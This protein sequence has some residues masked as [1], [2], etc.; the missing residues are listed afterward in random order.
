M[1]VKN[2]RQSMTYLQSQWH[3][4]TM[5]M[6]IKWNTLIWPPLELVLVRGVASSELDY[7]KTYTLN[8]PYYYTCRAVCI[9]PSGFWVPSYLYAITNTHTELIDNANRPRP[10]HTSISLMR[11]LWSCEKLCW[12]TPSSDRLVLA[13]PLATPSTTPPFPFTDTSLALAPIFSSTLG[14]VKVSG[15]RLVADEEEKRSLSGGWHN[16][17]D[18]LTPWY[19]LY[20]Q[21]TMKLIQCSLLQQSNQILAINIPTRWR[22]KE[23][24]WRFKLPHTV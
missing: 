17:P 9:M 7:Y 24:D 1:K 11:P 13:T 15:V 23:I 5:T 20:T 16:V 18:L 12:S 21:G 6:G 19:A 8:W 14:E 3:G 22:M 4:R 10:L 2:G